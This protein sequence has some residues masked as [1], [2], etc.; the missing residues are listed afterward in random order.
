MELH[1]IKVLKTEFSLLHLTIKNEILVEQ[2]LRLN[3]GD[4]L[5]L[6]EI[7]ERMGK[8]TGRTLNCRIKGI[9]KETGVI[10]GI[11][12]WTLFL[13]RL[14]NYNDRMKLLIKELESGK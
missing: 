8:P 6:V 14:V 1:Q 12:C 5:H 10:S 7:T 3:V 11:V 13:K 9:N 2:D 4:I